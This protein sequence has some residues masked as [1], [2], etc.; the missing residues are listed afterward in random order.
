MKNHFK[1]EISIYLK[2]VWDNRLKV[3]YHFEKRNVKSVE[4]WTITKITR[5]FTSDFTLLKS[6]W[7]DHSKVEHYFKG[8]KK[9]L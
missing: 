4:I 7:N 5:R 6:V 8:G 9:N 3:E 1:I 2:N